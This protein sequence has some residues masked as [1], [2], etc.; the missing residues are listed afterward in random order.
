MA[1][2]APEVEL[3]LRLPRGAAAKVLRHPLLQDFGAAPPQRARLQAVY[4][5]TPDDRLAAAGLALRL[6]RENGRW[7]QTLKGPAA[8]GAGAL[9]VRT[10]I[11]ADRGAAPRMPAL[12]A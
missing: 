2:P 10:E 5:D 12:D 7:I 4:F 3:K 6:R 8:G 1:G 11:Q 9:S